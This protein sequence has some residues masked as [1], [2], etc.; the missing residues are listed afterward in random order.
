MVKLH[1]ELL[2]FKKI[3][4]IALARIFGQGLFYFL[5]K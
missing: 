4:F 3:S 1:F 2:N 5:R